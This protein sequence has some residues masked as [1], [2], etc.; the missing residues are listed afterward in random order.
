[1]GWTTGTDRAPE[2][3]ERPLLVVLA[4]PTAVGKTACAVA[5]A[6]ALGTEVVSADARQIYRG[7]EIATAAPTASE[8]GDVPHHFVA[9]LDPAEPM[10]AGRYGEAARAVLEAVFARR[11]TA[12]LAG[13]SGLYIHAVLH[14]LDPLPAAAQMRAELRA[15]LEQR[16]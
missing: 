15:E 4:G 16:G 12:V 1:M 10:S 7:M 5:C 6:Q 2:A 3:G 11:R 9:C 8:M 14:G 13:G